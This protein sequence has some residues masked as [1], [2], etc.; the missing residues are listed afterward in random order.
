MTDS[1]SSREAVIWTREPT[2]EELD[3]VIIKPQLTSVSRREFITEKISNMREFVKGVTDK[4]GNEIEGKANLI[5]T[6]NSYVS[7]VE[8]FISIMILHIKPHHGNLDHLVHRYLESCGIDI[9]S[10]KDE[11]RNKIRRY[12]DMFCKFVS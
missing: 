6:L 11:D 8:S 1:D 3:E 2:Q 4:N 7:D 9:D 12:L 10:L 5:N